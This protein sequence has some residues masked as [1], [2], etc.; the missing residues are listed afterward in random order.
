MKKLAILLLYILLVGCSNTNHNV[1]NNSGPALEKKY[2]FQI[3][4][5][6]ENNSIFPITSEIDDFLDNLQVFASKNA[7]IDKYEGDKEKVL[8]HLVNR[9]LSSPYY[10][11]IDSN[12]KIVLGYFGE[13]TF[14]DNL[15]LWLNWWSKYNNNHIGF[16]MKLGKDFEKKENQK[17]EFKSVILNVHPDLTKYHYMYDLAYDFTIGVGNR[18]E[19]ATTEKSR[20]PITVLGNAPKVEE[21]AIVNRFIY[22]GRFHEHNAKKLKENF[23][24]K[25]YAHEMILVKDHTDSKENRMENYVKDRKL[26]ITFKEEVEDGKVKYTITYIKEEDLADL[27]Y[28]L[29]FKYFFD[30]N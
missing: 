17:V 18:F 9:I 30:E 19:I 1:T 4:R 20:K 21:L 7:T 10:K 16:E 14:R 28:D 13:T 5:L 11:E 27:I 8:N 15:K 6:L 22:D 29:N 23:N 3:E 12:K 2:E 24:E 26:A 25:D